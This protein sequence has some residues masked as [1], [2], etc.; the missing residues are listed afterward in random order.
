MWPLQRQEALWWLNLK[1]R[2]WER[3]EVERRGEILIIG[4]FRQCRVNFRSGQP[5]IYSFVHIII[6][7]LSL[8][9]RSLKAARPHTLEKTPTL[10]KTI[11]ELEILWNS[12][13][14]RY[15]HR[16]NIDPWRRVYLTEQI[17]SV[18]RLSYSPQCPMQMPRHN[19]MQQHD[20]FITLSIILIRQYWNKA[21]PRPVI[22]LKKTLSAAGNFSLTRKPYVG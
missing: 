6:F 4:E 13:N 11:H 16:N 12:M 8:T 2:K 21:N 15:C 18:S 14:G 7:F 17:P 10:I 22:E 9:P 19:Q 20:A 1:R 5:F 3:E